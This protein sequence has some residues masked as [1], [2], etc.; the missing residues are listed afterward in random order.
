V[1]S[2]PINTNE[3]ITAPLII[4]DIAVGLYVGTALLAGGGLGLLRVGDVVEVGD[5]LILYEAALLSGL[6]VL[7]TLGLADDVDDGLTVGV[8]DWVG[9]GLDVDVEDWVG[10]NVGVEDW[11]GVGLD[12]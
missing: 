11:V 1:T 10:L 12:V 3:A 5:M 2:I 6:V 8:E 7:D 4:P 9:V